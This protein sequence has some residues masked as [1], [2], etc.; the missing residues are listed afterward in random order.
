MYS[1]RTGSPESVRKVRSRGI[2][3]GSSG[4]AGALVD[5]LGGARE[6]TWYVGDNARTDVGGALAAGLRAIWFDWEGQTYPPDLPPPSGIVH[7][8][9]ELEALTENA[10]V[11]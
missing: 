10:S 2:D 4:G 3:A 1:S 9:R 7:A 6:A 5:A 11:P 8:L